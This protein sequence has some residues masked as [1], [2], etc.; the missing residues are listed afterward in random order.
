MAEGH[1][2]P[3][4]GHEHEGDEVRS[5]GGEMLSAL[6][7]PILGVGIPGMTRPPSRFPARP[8]SKRQASRMTNHVRFQLDDS[9]LEHQS[10][11]DVVP[12]W[13]EDE[14]YLASPANG[15]GAPRDNSDHRV[16]LLTDMDAPSVALAS[17]DL[18]FSAHDLLNLT[19]PKSGMRSAFMNMANSIMYDLGEFSS[20]PISVRAIG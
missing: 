7:E 20:N 12:E 14:D 5:T 1:P 8:S 11:G 6:D 19:R 10:N 13:V 4:S 18:D 9:P 3:D 16:P 17:G 2:P 15:A